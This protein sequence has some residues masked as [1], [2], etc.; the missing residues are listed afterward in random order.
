MDH[1]TGGGE[2]KALPLTSGGQNEGCH[3]GGKAKV[4]GDNFG[5]D[6]LHGVKDGE[7]GNDGSPRTVDVKVDGFGAIFFIEIK[8]DADD[9]VG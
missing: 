1:D 2:G 3:G 4:D 5:F 7:T 9:L 8:K 6:E